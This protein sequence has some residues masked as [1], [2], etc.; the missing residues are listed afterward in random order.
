MCVTDQN[1]AQILRH[2]S[3]RA[4]HASCIAAGFPER[5]LPL[6]RAPAPLQSRYATK[7][8]LAG[9]R[10]PGDRCLLVAVLVAGL[11]NPADR[12]YCVVGRLSQRVVRVERWLARWTSFPATMHPQ[13]LIRV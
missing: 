6:V 4:F 8:V 3:Q 11:C 5:K 9:C 12:V 2:L 13:P 10:C 7:S 1:C